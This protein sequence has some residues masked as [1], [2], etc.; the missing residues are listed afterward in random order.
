MTVIIIRGN[1]KVERR[2]EKQQQQ[3]Q[4][5]TTHDCRIVYKKGREG[6]QEPMPVSRNATSML[7]IANLNLKTFLD[8]RFCLLKRDSLFSGRKKVYH[9][10]TLYLSI[11]NSIPSNLVTILFLSVSL[12]LISSCFTLWVQANFSQI[13]K[14]IL[15]L[16]LTW[17]LLPRSAVTLQHIWDSKIQYLAM[18]QSW[19]SYVLYKES[20]VE[21]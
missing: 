3:S 9:I 16:R 19:V 6:L 20:M 21:W 7:A 4:W 5:G 12:P 14:L 18:V 11:D 17:S 2:E 15:A 1:L 8:D 13:T 10:I